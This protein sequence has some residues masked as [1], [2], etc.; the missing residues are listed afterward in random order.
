MKID[1]IDGKIANVFI[2]NGNTL[3]HTLPNFSPSALHS[4]NFMLPTTST[5]ELSFFPFFSSR[6]MKLKKFFFFFFYRR[7]ESWGERKAACVAPDSR[8]TFSSSCCR[9]SQGRYAIL[10]ENQEV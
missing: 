9:S 10:S 2:G 5:R 4:V 3:S 1:T 6:N 7:P 8:A